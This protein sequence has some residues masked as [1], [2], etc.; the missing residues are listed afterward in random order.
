MR[1]SACV[2][3]RKMFVS[4]VNCIS[5]AIDIKLREGRRDIL[6]EHNIANH[7]ARS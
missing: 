6:R 1:P 3:K 5:I 4:K 7:L 2:K